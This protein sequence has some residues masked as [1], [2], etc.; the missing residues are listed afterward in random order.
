MKRFLQLKL[1]ALFLLYGIAANAQDRTVSGKVTSAEDGSSIPGVNVLLKG[2][3]TGSVTDSEGRYNLSIPSTGGILVFSFIGL[4]TL[5]TEIGE[6]TVIDVSLSSD[7]TQLNEVIVTASGIKREVK[8]LG[9]G[10]ERVGGDKVSQVSEPDPLRAMS[11]KIAGVNIIGSSGSVGSATRITIRGSSSLLG[12]TQPLIVVDGIPYDNSTNGTFNQLTGGGAYGSRIQDIDPNNIAS[13]NVLKG[14]AAS[15]LYGTRGANGVLV[16]TT[17][18]GGAG[19]SKKG[20]EV[21]ISSGVAFEQISNLP[22]YQNTYGTGTGFAYQQVNGSWGAPFIGTRDYANVSTIPHWYDNVPGF[23]YLWGTTVPY[24]AYPN[25]TK[26]FFRTGVIYDNSIGFTAGNDRSNL[27]VIISNTNQTGYVPSEEFKKTN[28]SVGGNST[29]ENGLIIG[30]NLAY[31]NSFQHNTQGGAINA[32]GNGSAFGRI[33]FQGRNWDLFG[34]PYQNPVTNGSAYFVDVS[35]ADNPIWSTKNAGIESRTDRYVASFN[36][37]YNIKEWLNVTWR[38]GV[39]GYTQKQKDWFRPGSRGA[40]GSGQVTNFDVRFQELQ[41]D[42]LITLNRD[43]TPDLNLRAIL[44]QSINQRDTESQAYQGTGYVDF[45]INDIDNTNAV[46]PFGG[47]ISRRRIVGVYGDVSLGYKDYLFLNLTGRNDQSSTLPESKNSFFYPSVSAGFVFTEAFDGFPSIINYGKIRASYAEVGGD[48]GPYQIYQVYNVNPASINQTGNAFPFTGTSGATLENTARDPNLKPERTREMEAG[49]ELKGWDNRISVDLAVY[50]KYSSDQIAAIAIPNASGFT[51]LFTNI[52]ELSNKGVE[53]S[54]G[55]TPVKLSNGFS[56]DIRGVYTYN[57]SKV[58][59]LQ[60][61]NG[62]PI[63]EITLRNTFAGSVQSVHIV[64]QEY[65]LIK[66]TVSARDDEG[67]LLID[68]ANG[69]LIADPT[70]QVVG[71]P[72]PDFIIGITNTLS[73]KGIVLSAVFDWRQGGDLYSNTVNT[74]LGRGVTKDTEDREMGAIIPGVYGDPNTREPL[75]DE[76]GNKIPNQT[77]LGLNDFY[78]GNSFGINSQDEWAIWDATVFRL[79]EVVLG[80]TLP[81]SIL[82][83][84]PIGSARVS[85]SGRNLWYLAP[86][87]PEHTNF[88]PEISQFGNSNA[89][90][91]EFAA[92]PSVKRWGFNI[93]LTF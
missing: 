54:V 29:L 65:G 89:Q 60:M 10:V 66:G 13:I 84:T 86:N 76:S 50:K 45:Y 75:R 14:A 73:W 63:S 72:N 88:D 83:K 20:L 85:I 93:N 9:Y 8:S 47:G 64:G 58:E 18:T 53:L 15:A 51:G 26:D 61:P 78:F 71:N 25:N 56:W 31:T 90:G 82:S 16:I 6:R 67:N 28:F 41:S 42:F 32:V 37:G 4:Q 22:D 48:T 68:P 3:T 74:Y 21:S 1:L 52:G 11:G 33:L 49:L 19:P 70:P 2:T 79:R 77:N 30:G 80:Y 39:N 55:V 91:F 57:K 23:E 59:S 43:I 81:K 27:S 92:T 36:V 5:E 40:G 46:I 44:G 12:A 35:Q 34:Q 38:A 17:K 87:F 69:Q 62:L 24:K 7:A